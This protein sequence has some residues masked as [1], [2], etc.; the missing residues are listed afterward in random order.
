MSC[1][2]ISNRP[3]QKSFAKVSHFHNSSVIPILPVICECDFS[4]ERD[5]TTSP[6]PGR[7]NLIYRYLPI[8]GRN[9]ALRN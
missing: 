5:S 2:F 6:Q 7:V 1:G 8:R 3:L 9:A 4:Q